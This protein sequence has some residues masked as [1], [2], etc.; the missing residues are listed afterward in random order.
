MTIGENFAAV[1]AAAQQGE[2]WAW[3]LIYRDLSGPVTGYLWGRGASDPEDAASETFLQ[4]ARRLG[5]FSGDERAF[6]SWV[7]VIAHRRVLDDRRAAGRRPIPVS[8]DD[9]A[10]V[11]ALISPSAEDEA[12]PTLSRAEV[13]WLLAPLTEEQRDVLLLRVV[14]G[15][16]VK[17]AA[18]ALRKSAGAVK[19]LQ[20]RALAALRKAILRRP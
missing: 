20:H 1:L 8:D 2:E 16:S 18:D 7:F 3:D 10:A 4:V 12:I 5:S 19:V 13:V 11:S 9:L 14:G 6:R 15:L 17:E